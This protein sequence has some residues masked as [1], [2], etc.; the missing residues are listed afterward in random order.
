MRG[1]TLLGILIVLAGLLLLLSQVGIYNFGDFISDWWPMI[2]I[3]IGA[4]S[5]AVNAA[6]SIGGLL[7]VLVGAWFQLGKLDFMPPNWNKYLL[8]V[9]VM[10]I[11]LYFL[12][13]KREKAVTDTDRVNHVAIFSGINTR[14][15]SKNFKGGSITAIFGGVEID[16][17]SAEI[18][19]GSADM[20][21]TV[22]F[23][24]ADI[25][26]PGSWRV[27]VTGLPIFGGWSNKTK[28]FEKAEGA[29]VLRVRCLAMFGGV[30]IKA[31]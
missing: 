3:I 19:G 10:L 17:T 6:P 20:E 12:L 8:P 4:Y 29:P 31:R 14:N 18:A 26:V 30:D 11:G 24:G 16:L 9:I 22:A 28:D 15:E 23:G 7:L 13:T 21:T 5:L 25:V 27:E 2:L 1:R